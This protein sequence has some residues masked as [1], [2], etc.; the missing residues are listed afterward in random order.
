MVLGAGAIGLGVITFLKEG[1]AGLIIATEVNEKRAE[2]A[3]KLGA[4]YVFNPRKVP[5][6]REEVL[7]LTNGVGV[8][9]LFECSGVPQA[10]QSATDFLRPRGQIVLTGVITTD[11]S[12]VPLNINFREIQLQGSWCYNDEFPMVVDFLKRGV[13]SIQEMITSR[14]K[15]SNIVEQGFNELLRPSHNQIKILV[16]PK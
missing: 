12:I 2:V 11:T 4:N 3:K 1:G 6:L 5:N 13:S 9:Q 10:F 8:A 14:I 16:S 15:L 7:K